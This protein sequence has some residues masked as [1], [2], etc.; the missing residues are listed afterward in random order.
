[1]LSWGKSFM[2]K[3]RVKGLFKLNAYR[4]IMIA[5]I[6]RG[7][8]HFQLVW[9]GI[10]ITSTSN[11]V[12]LVKAFVNWWEWHENCCGIMDAVIVLCCWDP[13]ILGNFDLKS[14]FDSEKFFSNW[15]IYILYGKFHVKKFLLENF[16]FSNQKLISLKNFEF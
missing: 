6:Y 3:V 10:F 1:M 7:Q 16:S 14:Y 5:D 13:I 9:N 11:S 15:I 2:K 4:F 12:E 8:K